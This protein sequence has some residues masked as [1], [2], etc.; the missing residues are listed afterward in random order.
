MQW[1]MPQ[2]SSVCSR[3]QL[4]ERAV[5]QH[6]HAVA[7]GD[8]LETVGL[9]GLEHRRS[10]PVQCLTTNV[11]AGPDLVGEAPALGTRGIV[12]CGLDVGPVAA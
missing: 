9:E 8:R 3:R 12:E 7:V 5:P 1:F 2:I 10:C 11:A 6:H 4:V